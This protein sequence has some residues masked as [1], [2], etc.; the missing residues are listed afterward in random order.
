MC[1]ASH[2]VLLFAPTRQG[3]DLER[4]IVRERWDDAAPAGVARPA[5][6]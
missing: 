3:G 2:V 4:R 6:T 1:V 5:R